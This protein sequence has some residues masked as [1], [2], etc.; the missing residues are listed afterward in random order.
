MRAA[1]TLL[2]W[3]CA[4]LFPA[5]GQLLINEVLPANNATWTDGQGRSPDLLEL[6][7]AGARPV[8]LRGMR[9]ALGDR[10]HVFEASRIVP[11]KDHALL[12]ASGQVR[13]GPG[14]LAFRLPRSGG[15]LLLVAADGTTILDVFTWP[16]LPADVSMG[17]Q[18]DG[19]RG[20]SLF[21]PPTPGSANA[22]E[23]VHKGLTPAPVASVA[24][25][26]H[27]AP[28]EVVL[29]ACAG[30]EARYTL[31]GSGPDGPHAML[32]TAP[33]T[34][35]RNAVLRARAYAN[36]RLPGEELHATYLI[37]NGGR[38]CIALSMLPE[39]LHGD[40]GI[41]GPGV[42]ANN[43]RQG[44]KWERAAM[45]EVPGKPPAPVG[46]RLHG[47]GSRGLA[48][49]S[50]KLYAR[51]RYGS[52]D[53]LPLPG[54]IKLREGILRADASPHAFLRNRLMETLVTRCGLEVDVQRSEPVPLYLNG[55]YW[56][57]YRW[58]PA[59]DPA[60]SRQ[61]LGAEAVEVVAGPAARKVAGSARHFRRALE[62]IVSRAPIDTLEA[63]ID[64]PSLIDLA[65]IDLWSGRGDHDLNVRAHRPAVR[66]GRWRWVLF[67]MDLWAGPEENSL[68]R[69]AGA[70]LLE[71]PYVPW[72]LAHPQVAPKLLARL[73]ALQATAFHPDHA[74]PLVDSIHSAHAH[75]L[76]ADHRRWELEL[77]HPSPDV[78]RTAM[79]AFI[80]QR[81]AHLMRHLSSHTGH[82]QCGLEVE[83]PPPATGELRI[84]G[85]ALS[86]GVRQMQ[87]L[88]GVPLRFEAIPAAGYEFAGW[89]GVDG[90]SPCI[91]LDPVKTKK[92]RPLFRPIGQVWHV[93]R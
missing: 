9:L 93:G 53:A 54:G 52:P 84:E 88:N 91:T 86:P 63:L 31:D 15:T 17:R 35:D 62:A 77:E 33:I 70:Q 64:L 11:P 47:S 28:V 87:C 22:T 75:E 50:F 69:M 92:L 72:L 5:A 81:P 23:R 12:F 58:M 24:G 89:K 80:D 56:G 61:M 1:S 59:K 29:H 19:A 46:A 38:P 67:D 34:I 45:L 32:Y 42:S 74:I 13:P 27:P 8:D 85:L 14:H 36:D 16:A 18:P 49:R 6:Y 66:G 44:R 4:G 78:S 76:R 83:A 43:T 10:V 30:C 51:D 20:W 7:N 82:K 60:W 25:G 79:R 48:K 71:A 3:L 39:D 65:C 37:G 55:R 41:Y 26:Q 57:M 73:V 40:S 21:D 2:V 90:T 68:A